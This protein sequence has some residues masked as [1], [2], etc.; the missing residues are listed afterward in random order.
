MELEELLTAIEA[1]LGERFV[2]L[3]EQTREA[4]RAD[5][6]GEAF[7]TVDLDAGIRPLMQ[8]LA[9][10]LVAQMALAV[11]GGRVAN[12]HVC[13]CGKHYLYVRKQTRWLGFLF[14]QAQPRRAMYRCKACGET[15]IPLDQVWGLQSG[16]YA[17]GRRYLTPRAQEVL[18]G[19]CAAVPFAEAT[20]HFRELTGLD[21]SGMLGWRLVQ[22]LGGLLQQTRVEA[23]ARVGEAASQA[24]RWFIG[25]DGVMVAFWKG[26]QRRVRGGSAGS[27]AANKRKNRIEWREVKVGVVAQLDAAGAVVRGSQSYLVGLVKA[28]VFRRQMSRMARLRGVRPSDI[29]VVVTD[30]AKWLRA[31]WSRHFPYATAVRDF[32]HAA[33]HL[34]VMAVMLYGEGSRQATRWQKQMVGRLKDGDIALML[35]DWDNTR[36]TPK[37]VA[38]WRREKEYFRSQQEAMA[39]AKFREANLPIGSGA[40]EGACKS[41]V[42]SRFKRPGARW[43]EKGFANLAPLRARYSGGE[44]LMPLPHSC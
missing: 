24:R 19:L 5:A 21:V 17:M 30:G 14:G 35:A 23:S 27:E 40:V 22:H 12:R 26:E 16:M 20:R 4:L 10:L 43:S 13:P 44:P 29:V 3:I 8:M 1:A 42:A 9:G 31:L 18:V 38:G 6:A 34:G 37:D 15:R 11:D 32:F 36:R 41:T 33:E 2:P 25:A 39:Y 28:D 7:D